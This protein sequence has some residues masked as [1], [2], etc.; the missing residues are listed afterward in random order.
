MLYGHPSRHWDPTILTILFVN[1]NGLMT[2]RQFEHFDLD[3]TEKMVKIQPFTLPICAFALHRNRARCRPDWY[4]GGGQV[5]P[6]F[7]LLPLIMG[8]VGYGH[9]SIVVSKTRY[10][11]GYE[12]LMDDHA[13]SSY[14]NLFSA[15]QMD[16]G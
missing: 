7:C 9:P 13:Q 5:P 12:A 15:N 10:I 11:M 4:V 16:L 8:L 1:H 2:T 14:S 6:P 3:F